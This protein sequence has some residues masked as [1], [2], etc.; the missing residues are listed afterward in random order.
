MRRIAT[1]ALLAAVLVGTGGSA[2]AD[3]NPLRLISSC[4]PGWTGWFPLIHQHGPLYNYGPYS[5]YPPFEPYGN[6]NSYLQYTGP[7]YPYATGTGN[8]YGWIRGGHPGAGLG[9]GGQGHQLFHKGGK[10]D[11]CSTCGGGAAH[12]HHKAGC[13]SCGET[14]AN[15]LNA[16]QALD[17]F[18][19]VG[20]PAASA[21]YYAGGPELTGVLPAGA[22]E[23]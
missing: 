18:T 1:A 5:G 10:A 2:A 9:L 12:G 19:G 21:A 3:H 17:R 13:K 8:T 7:A 16:G 15:Y 20:R 6:W 11:G 23:N 22:T 4:P 14:A